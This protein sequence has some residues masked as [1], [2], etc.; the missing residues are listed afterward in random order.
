MPTDLKFFVSSN[1][2]DLQADK[3]TIVDEAVKYI[4]TLQHT[5]QTLEKQKFG[6]VQ[7]ATIVDQEKSIITSLIT[8]PVEAVFDSREAYLADHQ[9][10][11]VPKNL[12]MATNIHHSL[13]VP[14]PAAS[15]QTW[16]SP[17][18]VVNMCG[19]D[20]QISVCSPRKPG[21]LTTIFYILE[22]HNLDVVSA[23]VSSDRYRSMYMIHAHV[24]P[25]YINLTN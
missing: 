14:P 15:F 12:S 4:K 20:A 23:H 1:F 13:Q 9:G 11:S 25:T 10:S 3:S 17:N 2:N 5:H 7:G 22:K 16:F 8:S 24:S 6:K 18:V 21:L 19:D